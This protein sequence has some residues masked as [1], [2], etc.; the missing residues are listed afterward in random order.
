[1]SGRS[2]IILATVFGLTF[3]IHNTPGNC[4]SLSDIYRTKTIDEIFPADGS[5]IAPHLMNTG[6]F[7]DVLLAY[8]KFNKRPG[9]IVYDSS[10]GVNDDT[11]RVNK[12]WASSKSMTTQKHN[13]L[14]FD[15]K[16]DYVDLGYY[17]SALVL[18]Q[19]F[20]QEAWIYPT[21]SDNRYHGFLGN[22]N[23]RTKASAPGIWTKGLKVHYG[24]GDGCDWRSTTS[25]DVL[26]LNKWNHVAVTF[27]GIIYTLYV[28]GLQVHHT[29]TT[30]GRTP[31]ASP[32]RWIGR[33]GSYFEGMIYEVRIWNIT[34]SQD[35]IMKNLNRSLTGNEYGLVA[36][37]QFNEGFGSSVTD[38][39]GSANNGAIKG[40]PRW[41]SFEKSTPKM[42]DQ[43]HNA[44]EFDGSDDYVD[45]G[46]STALILGQTFT[47]EAWIYPTSS[48][49]SYQGFLG[50]HPSKTSAR[51]PGIWTKGLKVY[52]G[53][54]DGCAWR[55]TT[56]D[57]VL[58][59]NKWNHVAV[60]FD[61]TLYI[62]YVNGLQVHHTYT[63][64]GK[65]PYANPVRW[66]GRVDNH[67]E[68]MIYEARIWNVTRSQDEIMKSLNRSLTGEEYGLVA[69][70]KFNEG[71]G[72]T[73]TDRSESGNDGTIKGNPQWVVED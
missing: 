56:S 46:Y 28:N 9:R 71:S 51:A 40:N 37:Y 14:K 66:I 22:Q 17:S 16:D 45:L 68:G 58:T 33:D 47:Q 38:I 25:D 2:F 73:V 48:D 62:L 31:Y 24:F 34:R 11:I 18:R 1:M 52:Y 49:N 3:L 21:S 15:G 10:I 70:Y 57:D 29:Y 13:A 59:R 54:G 19:T 53:F 61:G 41:V 26:T 42:A 6:Q 55:S 20:T 63:A 30:S 8:Y 72:N 43:K 64:S 44:L 39:S 65:T 4:S 67:F 32:V 23:G 27:D 36:Y 69:Y 35:E 50:N 12:H 60:T 7:G 5:K